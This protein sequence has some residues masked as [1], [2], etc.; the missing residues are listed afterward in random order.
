MN[1]KLVRTISIA[2][3]MIVSTQIAMLD[4]DVQEKLDDKVMIAS[5]VPVPS[6]GC[7]GDDACTGVDAG[8]TL[9]TI[10]DLTPGVTF[11]PSATGTDTTF[12][13]YL[14]TYGSAGNDIYMLSVPWG[15]SVEA[16]TTWEDTPGS[17]TSVQD[18]IYIT[19]IYTC[20]T[21]DLG[22]YGGIG[23]G[24]PPYGSPCGVDDNYGSSWGGTPTMSGDSASTIGTDVGGQDIFI[25]IYCWD[26]GW[27]SNPQITDYD[28]TIR[29]T[30]SD[31]GEG[32]YGAST[33]TTTTPDPTLYSCDHPSATA[34]ACIEQPDLIDNFHTNF[35]GFVTGYDEG[36]ANAF[37]SYTIDIPANHDA[38]V[39]LT[40]DCYA[41]CDAYYFQYAYLFTDGDGSY[42]STNTGTL[43]NPGNGFGN[44]GMYILDLPMYGYTGPVYDSKTFIVAGSAADT[45]DLQFR[46]PSPYT[47]AAGFTYTVSIEYT[48][49]AN[50]PC[51]TSNDGGSG[52]DAPDEGPYTSSESTLI[53]S[54]GQITGTICQD[55]DDEDFYQIHV[56]SGQGVFASLEW[57]DAGDVNYAGLD[58]SMT[59]NDGSSLR[60]VM[61]A[62]K[63]DSSIQSVSSNN[64]GLFMPGTL[65]R[66]LECSLESFGSAVDSCQVT[67][68]TGD[69]LDI[70]LDTRSWGSEVMV[71]VTEPDGTSTQYGRNPGVYV[72]G[73][74]IYFATNAYYDLPAWEWTAPGTYTVSVTDSYGDGCTCTLEV[75]R[76]YPPTQQANDVVF[77]VSVDGLPEDTVVN[78]TINYELYNVLMHQN[79]VV[80]DSAAGADTT[81]TAPGTLYSANY[82]Y[83]GYLHDAWDSEDYYEIFV[84]ENYGITV[85]VVSDVK[86]DIDLYSSF[87]NNLGGSDPAGPI[88]MVYNSAS[89]GSTETI[90]LN[91]VVGSGMY[92]M[93][94]QMWTVDNGPDASQDDAGTGGDAADHHLDSGASQWSLGGV[95]FNDGT[96]A[97]GTV[98]WLNASTQNATGVPV[99]SS[100]TGTVNHVWDRVDAYR[101][102][103]P[104]GYYANITVSSD[105][106]DGVSATI[107][108][109]DAYH[110]P[111]T[112]GNEGIVDY[113][114]SFVNPLESQTTHYNEG[115]FVSISIWSY[116][117]VGDIDF[118]YDID[119][120]WDDISNLP[121]A[122]DDAGTCSDAPDIYIDCLT[123]GDCD[124]GLMMNSTVGVNHTFSG[125][126]HS[127]LDYRDFYNF[128]V[129]QDY[130]IEITMSAPTT[131]SYS[132][133]LYSSTGSFLDSCY[134]CDDGN[135]NNDVNTNTSSTFTGGEIVALYVRANSYH[136]ETTQWYTITYHIF[137]LDTDGDTW[138]DNEETDCAA[139][140][141]TGATYD[142]LDNTSYPP[143]NDADGICDELDSD[144]DN[145]G[146]DDTLDQ[147]PF[148]EN[149]SGDLDGDDIGDN[150]DD[151]IDGDG[152][153]NVDE[154]NC[155][156]DAFDS[157]SFPNDMDADG[158]C[159]PLDLDM[160]GDGVTNDADYYPTDGGA[161]VNTDGDDYPDEIHPGWTENASAYLYDVDNSVFETTLMA[162][163]DDDN[164]G[165]S[166]TIEIDCMSDPLVSTNVPIDSDGDGVC[167]VNDD[168]I[169]GDGV[170]NDD[171]AFPLSACAA[172]DSDGDGYPDT[173]VAD[174]ST[175]LVE[176]LDDDNDGF[177]DVVDAF[178]LDV[179]EWYDTDMDGIGNNADMNDDGDAWTDSEEE[180]CGSDALDGDSVPTD[181]DGDMICDK[182]D[183]DDDG[184]GVVD[185]LDAF[186]FDASEFSDNDGD[187]LGDYSDNDDDNDGWLDDEEPNC[188]TDSMDANSVP[189]DNDMDRDCDI[190][191]QDDDNDGV[192]DIDDAFPMNPAEYRD[193]DDDGIGD[194]ADDDDDGDGW[195][196]TT[197]VLCR[198]A[199]GGV[200]DPNN[201]DVYPIDNETDPG[202]DGI[203][204][205]DDD[206]P[207]NI[208]GD[209]VCNA[210][211][212]DDD[213]DGVPDPA[214][215][216]LDANGVCTSCEDWEDHFPW[217]PTE[218]FD[219]NDDGKG[220]NANSLTLMDDIKSDPMPFIG[221]GLVIGL[222]VALVA[223]TASGRGDGDE[224]DEF[225]ETEEFLD[226]DEEEYEE[227]IDA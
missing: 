126:A 198:N 187:G 206:D 128:D 181:Y 25:Q 199:Q 112:T 191:D 123:Q 180:D 213:N 136:D 91:A 110:Q 205:T 169:D 53:V 183:T 87:G 142:P 196:D 227:E 163:S 109:P 50:A 36:G 96:V 182:L 226:E 95:P 144:D 157:S 132:M 122:A 73:T 75:Y 184:D 217:D 49:A 202:A 82:S 178:S 195:L 139:A 106:D 69:M 80:A 190:T 194:N 224:F 154:T 116:N 56:P 208:I 94:V 171:D 48:P 62:T 90:T 24:S 81:S 114:T 1:A 54:G 119:V 164:D 170:S 17:G 166:D 193:L 177:S 47:S 11:T 216:V 192:L 111:Y 45:F 179:T 175:N 46:A 32:D 113:I 89:G 83:T 51:A 174:C 149:E 41:N 134:D 151:D 218:Q 14:P 67:L 141:T 93:I 215:Y 21:F 16:I 92:T 147:F 40:I 146:I 210:L 88:T 107:F 84:P 203:Y 31:G 127:A 9:A 222:L 28:L 221:I 189:A 105:E 219:G 137:S 172:V 71:T 65:A 124:D 72:S 44:T 158:T 131:T 85:S 58:L 153:L 118:D 43:M 76:S 103:I 148:D 133:T 173:L 176:D 102:A 66:D 121:C 20:D 212:P 167:D 64:S 7:L 30:P 209:G 145:D 12:S 3:L 108:A 160:D 2:L 223:R 152:W 211:D 220:D 168:D 101:L 52:L 100:M 19:G 63:D 29:V 74:S 59:V 42:Q 18:L 104:M 185:T 188:G 13:G 197:E 38:T 15:Y 86:N 4:T 150:A 10:I 8:T 39:S 161:S 37:D 201:K 159:D 140:S 99:D 70:E 186:P 77:E 5:T 162:D 138:L 6:S 156:T 125:W 120:E 115:H 165:Y 33:S 55:Y 26:C 27:Y 214:V 61:S 143:D 78:Y 57:D 68:T 98:T 97:D 34:T 130:G 22:L 135:V 200:G 117:M 204:G 129:P 79:M 35:T 23:T 155:L 60:S 225:D 207:T